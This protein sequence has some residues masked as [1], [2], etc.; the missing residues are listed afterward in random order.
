MSGSTAVAVVLYDAECP[1]CRSLATF[2]ARIPRPE[3]TF[4]AWQDFRRSFPPAIAALPADRLRVFRDGTLLEQ[5]EAW[6][7]LLERHPDLSALNWLA[8]KLGAVR[9]TGKALDKA[10]AIARRLCFRCPTP[11]N[12]SR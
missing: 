10:G 2:A 5:E 6:A 4:A 11:T 12:W 3:L 9:A 7:Y 1:L 8:E